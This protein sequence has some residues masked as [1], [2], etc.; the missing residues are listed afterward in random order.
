MLSTHRTKVSD[1]DDEQE[2]EQLLENELLQEEELQLHE[3][4]EQL[5]EL[6]LDEEQLLDEPP[7]HIIR[8]R[9]Y[10]A[11]FDSGSLG[12]QQQRRLRLFDPGQIEKAGIHSTL[13]GGLNEDQS[14]TSLLDQPLP[15]GEIRL[16]IDL[17]THATL[18]STG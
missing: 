9:I 2:Q 15:T 17:P 4:H 14:L 1:E 3:E 5:L 18:L 12:S 10:A 6:Q 13:R 16:S 11:R 8:T 7:A